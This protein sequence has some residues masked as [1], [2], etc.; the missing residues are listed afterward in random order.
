MIFTTT[1]EEST[2]FLTEITA[3][4]TFINAVISSV[5]AEYT[6]YCS[7][8]LSRTPVPT[9]QTQPSYRSELVIPT[10]ASPHYVQ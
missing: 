3:G 8:W 9:M 7:E 5:V 6:I 4:V 2:P 10:S 1:C